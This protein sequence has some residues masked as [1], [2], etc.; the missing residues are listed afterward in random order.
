MRK[1]CACVAFFCLVQVDLACAAP[2]AS[3]TLT[4]TVLPAPAVIT[5]EIVN[6]LPREVLAAGE[7]VLRVQHRG[8]GTDFVWTIQLGQGVKLVTL[9][10]LPGSPAGP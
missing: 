2:S 1:V 4:L 6:A 3:Q 10:V 7:G 5:P 9:A 8:V